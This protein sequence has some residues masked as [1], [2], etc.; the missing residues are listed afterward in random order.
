MNHDIFVLA[1]TSVAALASVL[2]ATPFGIAL[3]RSKFSGNNWVRSVWVL[4]S[5]TPPSL[6][7]GDA[8]HL[9]LTANIG[10]GIPIAAC[11]IYWIA[12]NLPV[13]LEAAARA[14]GSNAFAVLRPPLLPALLL[15]FILVFVLSA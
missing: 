11:V 9:S 12:K 15:A 6:L 13:D 1:Q 4:A 14:D 7:A 2:I 3:A 8:A 5:A 10:A